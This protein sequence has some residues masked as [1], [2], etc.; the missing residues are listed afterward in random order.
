MHKIE[1]RIDPGDAVDKNLYD[2]SPED[3]DQI[4]QVP[5]SLKGSL[6]ALADDHKFLVK[7]GVFTED[8]IQNFIELKNEEYD[9]VRI[10]THPHEYFLYYDI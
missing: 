7:G 10:R 3:A 5:D 6:D 1:N 2:L 4:K 9:D 8:F